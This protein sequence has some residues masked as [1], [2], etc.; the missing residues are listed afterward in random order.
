MH[1]VITPFCWICDIL[2]RLMFIPRK[3]QYQI[4]EKMK[5]IKLINPKRKLQFFF[6]SC[7]VCLLKCGQYVFIF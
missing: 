6:H 3:Q 2:P 7:T 1:K 4:E 5:V